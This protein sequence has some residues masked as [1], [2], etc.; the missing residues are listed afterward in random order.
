MFW[1]VTLP[2]YAVLL[3]A[4]LAAPGL[5]IWRG[6]PMQWADFALLGGGVALLVVATLLLTFLLAR[7]LMPVYWWL[8]QVKGE[9]VFEFDGVY[10][11]GLRVDPERVPNR[12]Q[13]MV[14]SADEGMRRWNLWFGVLFLVLLLPH[15]LGM[16]TAHRVAQDLLPAPPRLAQTA[17]E[18]FL[19]NLPVMQDWQMRW[20]PGP[21]LAARLEV[22]LDEV[23]EEAPSRQRAFRAAQLHLLSAFAPRDRASAP[24][25]ASPGEAVFFERA[26]GARAMRALQ[27]LTAEGG[28]AGWRGGALALEGF[29]HLSVHDYARA[30][31][32]L[33]RALSAME[34][35]DSTGLARHQV[36]LLA[37]H[38]ATLRG[39]HARAMALLDEVLVREDL[40]GTVYALALEH[41]AGTLRLAGDGEQARE[42]LSRARELYEH[43]RDRAGIARVHLRLAALAVTQGRWQDA[44]R[45]LSVASSLATGLQDGFTLNM[46]A[47]L[48]QAFP[49]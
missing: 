23:E 12:V 11:I 34:G 28:P 2:L 16:A 26:V 30:H 6:E 25:Y 43:E 48:A 17:H 18:A 44:G 21:E 8:S 37:A 49:G 31:A 22:A 33:E 7:L 29:F 10:F 35:D 20:R 3:A 38:T 14:F 4:G 13:R 1:L 36:L 41:Y 40:P 19:S 39:R 42:L 5:V 27:P 24:F 47:R 46:I 9:D 15:L 32:T 45:E